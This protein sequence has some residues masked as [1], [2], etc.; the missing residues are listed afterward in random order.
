MLSMRAYSSKTKF[1]FFP[2]LLQQSGDEDFSLLESF[3]R[4]K[5]LLSDISGR[6]ASGFLISTCSGLAP[7]PS[8]GL[9]EL[10]P[11]SF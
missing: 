6:I 2:A 1:F 10:R 9:E 8:L 4:T 5:V 11:S 3:A 7:P